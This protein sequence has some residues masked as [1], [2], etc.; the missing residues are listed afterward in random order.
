MD[1]VEQEAQMAKER[2]WEAQNRHSNM[3]EAQELKPYHMA[4]KSC[5][6]CGGEKVEPEYLPES[7]PNHSIKWRGNPEMILHS[8]STC[9]AELGKTRTLKDSLCKARTLKDSL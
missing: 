3:I 2:L 4:P 9:G 7:K 8:C 6:Y 5:P 1:E